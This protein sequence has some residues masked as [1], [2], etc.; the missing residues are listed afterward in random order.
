MFPWATSR[1][2]LY[3]AFYKLQE[4]AGIPKAERFGFHAL[5]RTF[6]T[7][8]WATDPSAAQVGLPHTCIDVTRDFYVRTEGI[9]R[10]GRRFTSCPRHSTRSQSTGARRLAFFLAQRSGSND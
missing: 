4:L 1:K 7:A 10:R 3:D 9:V 6:A 8:M 5:R 2:R